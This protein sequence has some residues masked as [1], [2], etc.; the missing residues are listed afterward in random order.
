MMFWSSF[1]EQFNPDQKSI[2]THKIFFFFNVD[3]EGLWE[4]LSKE[5]TLTNSLS[6]ETTSENHC[7]KRPPGNGGTDPGGTLPRGHMPPRAG[8]HP[9]HWHLPPGAR[10]AP[11]CALLLLL[12][13][14]YNA[15]PR[16]YSEADVQSSG[17]STSISIIDEI[18]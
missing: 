8:R 3:C 6:K 15:L 5:T 17:A 9:L 1:S 7:Q 4:F 12:L 2:Y 13:E 14:S 18:Q 10:A 16:S 11:R